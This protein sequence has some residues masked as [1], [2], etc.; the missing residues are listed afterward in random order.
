MKIKI[1]K[2]KN[3]HGYAAICNNHLTEGRTS[4]QARDRMLK[5]LRRP[6]KRSK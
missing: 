3:R 1:F 6:K 2:I 4:E 5:A